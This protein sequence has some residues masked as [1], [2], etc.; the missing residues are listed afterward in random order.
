[1]RRK[2]ECIAGTREFFAMGW[3][4]HK[5]SAGPLRDGQKSSAFS[6]LTS[7]LTVILVPPEMVFF[8]CN[9]TVHAEA[10]AEDQVH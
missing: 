5:A 4:N 1:M 8:L 3:T 2:S 9:V 6:F 7:E 10:R